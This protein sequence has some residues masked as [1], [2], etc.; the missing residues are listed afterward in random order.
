MTNQGSPRSTKE[1]ARISGNVVII[2]GQWVNVGSIS[3]AVVVSG[4]IIITGDAK[5]AVCST[6]TPLLTG[7]EY[8]SN[9]HD[10]ENYA[11]IVGYAYCDNIGGVISVEQS[12]DSSNFDV[13]YA[14]LSPDSRATTFN[15]TV[16]SKFVR[17]KYITSGDQSTFRLNSY[18]SAV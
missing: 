8:T 2:S 6:D 15:V 16:V 13:K 10:A 4:S 1:P 11:R 14:I 18:L 9:V 17:V 7:E 5:V 12:M 3:G